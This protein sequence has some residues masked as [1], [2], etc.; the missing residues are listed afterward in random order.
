MFREGVPHDGVFVDVRLYRESPQDSKREFT[1]KL[2]TI[3]EE[4]LGL[5]KERLQVNFLELSDWG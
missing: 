5:P 1:Q 2:S 4:V 3:F